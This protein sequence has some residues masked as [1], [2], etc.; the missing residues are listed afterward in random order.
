MPFLFFQRALTS[1]DQAFFWLHEQSIKPGPI[2]PEILNLLGYEQIRDQLAWTYLLAGCGLGWVWAR[3]LAW[4]EMGLWV[5]ALAACFPALVYYSFLVSTDLLYAVL[6]A[7]FYATAWAILFRKQGAWICC[8]VVLAIAL[9]CRPNGLV[10]IP[11]LFVLLAVES[12][13]KWPK[14]VLWMLIWG[15]FGLY[16]LVYY[17]PYFWVHEGNSAGTTYW[18]I[19]PRQFHEGLFLNWPLWLNKP[20]SMLILGISKVIYSVGLRPSYS[21]IS[22]WLVLVRA[23]PGLLFLP[24]LIYGLWRGHWFDR[25]FV[26][27]FLMPVYVGAAQERYLLA[28]TPLL[29]LWGIKAYSAVWRNWV[30]RYKARVIV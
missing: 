24:G 17:L 19:Y 20:A 13:V 8:M 5:Q 28:L 21:E 12:S 30:R 26:F 9:L 29:L 22:P 4:R 11:V 2:F 7:M 10:I 27:F 14:R 6:M 16:M 18:G 15:L 1:F 25:V 3:F 23:L